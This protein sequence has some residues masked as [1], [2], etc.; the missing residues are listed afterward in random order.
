MTIL[1]HTIYFHSPYQISPMRSRILHR[2]KDIEKS[3]IMKFVENDGDE[4]YRS[5]ILKLGR[6]CQSKG[7]DITEII[8]EGRLP[9]AVALEEWQKCISNPSPRELYLRP[10]APSRIFLKLVLFIYSLNV[11]LFP[12]PPPIILHPFPFS[13][14]RLLPLPLHPA[15]LPATHTYPFPRASSLYGSRCILFH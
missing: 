12:V 3:K 7:Q 1:T 5:R 8:G 6:M 14:K 9:Q 13:S 2:Y 15:P 11:A 10:I 4:K